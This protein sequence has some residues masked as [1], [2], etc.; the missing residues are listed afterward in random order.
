MRNPVLDFRSLNVQ[1]EA[2]YPTIGLCHDVNLVVETPVD[3]PLRE[4]QLCPLAFSIEYLGRDS[5]QFGSS[6]SCGLCWSMA[7]AP[8]WQSTASSW[9]SPCTAGWSTT[10][11]SSAS[12]R[13]STPTAAATTYGWGMGCLGGCSRCHNSCD[14]R[15]VTS[16]TPRSRNRRGKVVCFQFVKENLHGFCCLYVGFSRDDNV[17]V[18]SLFL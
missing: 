16:P 1:E 15:D 9:W 11:S 17:F 5:H 7:G 2:Q 8:S 14:G 6:S 12:C 3:L 18:I 13:S 10:E 4:E